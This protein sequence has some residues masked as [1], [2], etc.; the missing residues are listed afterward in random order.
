MYTHQHPL[1]QE[2]IAYVSSLKVPWSKLAG[3]VVLVTGCSGMIGSCLIDVIMKKNADIGLGCRI[4]ALGRNTSRAKIRFSDYWDS[5]LFCFFS[6]DINNISDYHRFSGADY[7]IHLASNT[8]PVAYATDPVSTIVTNV[9]GTRNLLEIAKQKDSS[10]FIFASSNE[11]YGENRGDS[12]LFS[13]DYCGYIDCNSLRAGYPESKRCGEALCQAFHKQFGTDFV[14]SRFTRTYGPTLQSSDTKALSQFLWRGLNRES[15]ILKS[16]GSQFF[17]YS[18]VADAVAGLLFVLLKGETCQA[19]NIADRSSDVTLKE[20]AQMIAVICGTE[21]VFNLPD[22]NEKAGF[23]KVT[24]ARLD[25]SKLKAL[26]WKM[27]YGIEDGVVRTLRMMME[28]DI[29]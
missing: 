9:L 18:Y 7:V 20:L 4:V 28:T 5:P 6:I 24:K 19:Y 29:L 22:N 1:Y 21:V 16:D 14:I 26:G 15:I 3:K 17:S 11:I 8:H 25:G 12:E 27:N 23:S 13:E 2:D 10:R